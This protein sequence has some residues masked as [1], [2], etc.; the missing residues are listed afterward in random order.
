MV[1]KTVL[2]ISFMAL[3][4]SLCVI[5]ASA[6]S[7]PCIGTSLFFWG[8]QIPPGWVCGI[9]EGPFSL[10]CTGPTGKCVSLGWC[11]TCG[12]WVVVAGAPINLTSGN[13]YIQ[14]QDIQ[15]PGLGGGLA[16]QRTWNSIWPLGTNGFQSGMFGLNWRSTYEESVF[17]GSGTATNYMVYER[18]DGSLWYFSGSGSSYSLVSPANTTASLTNNGTTW[19]LTFLNGEKRQFNFA[20]GNL[21]AIVD[22]NGNTTQLSYDGLNRPVTVADPV[23][24]HLYFQYLNNSSTSPVSS[25][26]SDINLS[27]SYAYDSQGRLT[28]V[29]KPDQTTISFQYNANSLISAVLDQQGKVL[30]S[31]TYDSQGRGLTSA[32]ANGVDSVTVSYHCYRKTPFHFFLQIQFRI[33]DVDVE[34]REFERNKPCAGLIVSS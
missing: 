11:P 22:R 26:T 24:R 29:T 27:L 34:F 19:T 7:S 32:R 12:K 4:S 16:L 6:Q 25:V 21:T 9:G 33:V 8:D 15:V 1:K 5:R 30:E 3:V 17:A 2:V 20:L 18:A 14:E 31:H 28:Q 23:G 13:T 10:M